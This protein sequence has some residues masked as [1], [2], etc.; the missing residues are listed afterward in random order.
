[1]KP[2]N[3]YFLINVDE[4]YAPK[5]YKI[6]KRGQMAKGEWPEGAID[7]EEWK[8]QTFDVSMS[9]NELYDERTLDW[10]EAL[11]HLYYVRDFY[12]DP[13]TVLPLPSLFHIIQ[14]LEIRYKAGERSIEL[15]ITMINL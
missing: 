3:R 2:G 5:I 9:S 11:R 14:Y 15:F 13:G 10:D 12:A 8:L 4:P 7:F 6:L 1:M